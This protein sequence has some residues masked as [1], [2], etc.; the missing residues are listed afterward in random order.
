MSDLRWLSQELAK[1][2]SIKTCVLGPGVREDNGGCTFGAGPHE[3][4]GVFLG[5]TIEWHKKGISWEGDGKHVRKLVE[6]WGLEQ[7]NGVMTPGIRPNKAQ[8][9]VS[10]G[11]EEPVSK[12]EEKEYRRG[13][14]MLNYIAQDRPDMPFA[15]KEVSRWMSAPT[16]RSFGDLKRAIRYLRSRPRARMW[17]PWQE[18]VYQLR[19]FSDS[20]WAGCDKTRRSTTGGV[21]MAGQHWLGHWSRTQANVALSSGEAEL[22]AAVTACSEG[23]GLKNLIGEMHGEMSLEIIGDSSASMG[24]LNRTGAGRVKHLEVKQ[25]WV[26]ECIARKAVSVAK[27]PRR[28]NLADSLT[29]HWSIPENASHFLGMGLEWL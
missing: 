25:L 13:S 8:G 21:I 19:V 6:E 23:R 16:A 7:C 26:Q 1:D 29:H 4:K 15:S 22:N 9:E 2:L 3:T 27:V 18:P 10:K 24:I 28:I 14:A 11:V 20:D 17:Y 12:Q 5:R